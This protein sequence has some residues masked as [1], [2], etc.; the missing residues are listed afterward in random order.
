MVGYAS[1]AKATTA[2]NY[3]GITTNEI[4]YIVEDNPLKHNKVLPGC[5]IPI[6]SKDKLNEKLPDIIVVM[7]WNFVEEI[8]KNNQDL[9]D[10]GVRFISIK[11]LQ[12]D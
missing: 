7:A 8:K 9:I 4:E 5:K 10:K 2:L 6:Y 11:E 12:N 3:Y 1:P